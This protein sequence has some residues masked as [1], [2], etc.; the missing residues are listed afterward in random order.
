MI[1]VLGG[2]GAALAWAAAALTATRASRSAGAPRTLAWVMLVGLVLIS[3]TLLLADPSTLSAHTIGLLALAGCGNVG[4]LALEYLALRAGPVGVVA[5]IASTEGAMA[6][7]IAVIAGQGP[8]VPVLVTLAALAVGV[9]LSAAGGA[10]VAAPQAGRYRAAALAFGAAGLFAVNLY[11]LG[12]V[13]G[14]TS[15]VWALWPARV[16]GT[17]TVALPLAAQGKLRLPG[18]ALAYAAASGVAEVLGILAYATGARHGVAVPAVV[19]SQFAG[20]AAVG[21]YFL[22]SERLAR[23]QVVGLVIIAVGVAVLAALQS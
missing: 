16:V 11:A 14:H 22:L 21:G 2:L 18:P 3:P 1:G 23:R 15:V 10:R 8:S 5:P 7:V 13:G 12:R 4:G 20:L 17:V 19:G 6:A 9:F